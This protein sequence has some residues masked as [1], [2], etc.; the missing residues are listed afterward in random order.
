MS[1]KLYLKNLVTLSLFS[2]N[3]DRELDIDVVFGEIN[4]L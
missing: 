4:T 2:E 3:N 1:E